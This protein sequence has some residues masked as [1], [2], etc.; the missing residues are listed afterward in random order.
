MGKRTFGG[1]SEGEGKRLW[2]C[3]FAIGTLPHVT[4]TTQ[5]QLQN[6]SEIRRRGGAYCRRLTASYFTSQGIKTA[7]LSC[8]GVSDPVPVHPVSLM[9]VGPGSCL[10][11]LG[12]G[13]CIII[14]Q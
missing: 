9:A 11:C 6:I 5:H 2:L 3:S 7:R 10:R 8:A 13:D 12:A 14:E 1:S 4:E